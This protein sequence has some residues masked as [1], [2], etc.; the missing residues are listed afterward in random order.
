MGD[1]LTTPVSGLRQLMPGVEFHANVL[2]AMRKGRQVTTLPDW[3]VMMICGLLAL[4][5]LL[6]LPRLPPLQGLVS[7]LLWFVLVAAIAIALPHATV[8]WLLPSGALLA[9][10]LAYPIWS[11]RKLESAS[12]FLDHELKHLH[13]ELAGDTERLR[14]MLPL[15]D[16]DPFQARIMQ[17]QAASGRLRHLQNERKE[18]LAFISHDIRAP[19]AAA[20]LQLEESGEASGKLHLSLARA[21]QLAEDFLNT[22]RAEMADAASFQGVDLGA[23]LHQAVDDAYAAARIK[24]VRLERELPGSLSGYQA[25]LVYCIEPC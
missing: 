4:A 10:L 15:S 6:W 18:T 8:Y 1:L 13:H 14:K 11:W 21:L 16:S 2:E 7:S 23:V 17:V 5:P 12:R 20:L 22:S 24:S 19:L 3:S 9:N 25:I